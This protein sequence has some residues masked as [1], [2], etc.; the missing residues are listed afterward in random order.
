MRARLLPWWPALSEIYGIRPP[1]VGLYSLA[2]LQGY[3][4][5]LIERAE[6]MRR[7]AAR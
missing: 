4:D 7:H 3:V 5:S 1:D 2:E 6:A